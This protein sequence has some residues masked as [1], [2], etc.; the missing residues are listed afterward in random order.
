MA[1]DTA[2]GG[3]HY[4]NGTFVDSVDGERFDVVNP[5]TGEE[6][7]T[8]ARGKAA[9]VDA[10]VAAAKDTF[11]GGW[12]KLSAVERADLLDK[13]ADGIEV[14]GGLGAPGCAGAQLTDVS[15]ACQARKE[16][17]A[18]LESEDTGK[19]LRMATT[20]DIPRAIANFRCERDPLPARGLR[21]S[22][23]AAAAP[24]SL[25]GRSATMRQHAMQ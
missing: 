2:H 7:A 8:M 20:V 4:I 6:V 17:L 12:R 1:T 9:D 3:R 10:A 19:T 14:R 21:A 5:A 18:R 11:H 25:Q 16:E 22:R 13:I 23:R 15:C 24:G